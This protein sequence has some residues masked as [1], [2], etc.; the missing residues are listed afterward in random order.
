[1]LIARTLQLPKPAGP[2]RNHQYHEQLDTH[3]MILERRADIERSD[4]MIYATEK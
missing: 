2:M 1:M 3:C 4:T